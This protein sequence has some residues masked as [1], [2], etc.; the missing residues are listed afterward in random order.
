MSQQSVWSIA[1]PVVRLENLEKP[2]WVRDGGIE[3]S[4]WM[5]GEWL[6]ARC[7]WVKH[8]EMVNCSLFC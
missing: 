3:G 2:V 4:A 5:E 7:F 6:P 1:G 8:I